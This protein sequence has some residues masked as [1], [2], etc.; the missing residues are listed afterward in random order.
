MEK[1]R[2]DIEMEKYMLYAVGD[3]VLSYE[4]YLLHRHS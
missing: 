4:E 2:V 1:K 3:K